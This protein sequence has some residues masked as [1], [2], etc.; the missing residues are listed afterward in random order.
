MVGRLRRSRVV[1]PQRLRRALQ[2][3]LAVV[4]IRDGLETLQKLELGT[5]LQPTPTIKGM[6]ARSGSASARAR[7]ISISRSTHGASIEA[8]ETITRKC[9][10][11]L[12]MAVTSGSFQ[13]RPTGMLSGAIQALAPSLA[14]SPAR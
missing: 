12:R 4:R 10:Q 9:E 2:H 1:Q 5:R 13:R 11:S 14:S 6:T 3:L 7:A 8:A